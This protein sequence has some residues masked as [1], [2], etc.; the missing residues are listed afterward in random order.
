M[1]TVLGTGVQ[2]NDLEGGKV[3]ADQAISS[4]WDV[5]IGDLPG[6]MSDFFDLVST[7]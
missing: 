3:G 2:G 4:P 5:C 7:V 6:R 1:V